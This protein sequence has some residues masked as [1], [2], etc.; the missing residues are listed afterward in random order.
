[1]RTQN[2][3]IDGPSLWRN[4][5]RYAGRKALVGGWGVEERLQRTSADCSRQVQYAEEEGSESVIWRTHLC[6]HCDGERCV[7]SICLV[8]WPPT[9]N[10]P[11]VP[12][13]KEIPCG[14]APGQWWWMLRVDAARGKRLFKERRHVPRTPVDWR[15]SLR[16]N[17]KALKVTQQSII[18]QGLAMDASATD[19]ILQSP[20]V[21][22]IQPE[23]CEGRWGLRR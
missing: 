13:T 11:F 2:K 1:M 6:S 20:G 23:T 18:L 10:A 19:P 9:R 16:L 4:T 12:L 17:G 5:V 7:F 22:T 8:P 3:F 21:G 14:E 15:H